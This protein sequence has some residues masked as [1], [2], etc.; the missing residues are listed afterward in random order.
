M[1][2]YSKKYNASK[3]FLV[4]PYNEHVKQENESYRNI[5]NYSI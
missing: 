3:V 2:V 1:H 4:Y 5:K